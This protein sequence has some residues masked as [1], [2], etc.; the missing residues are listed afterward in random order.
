MNTTKPH[1]NLNIQFQPIILTLQRLTSGEAAYASSRN[2]FK[3]KENTL[4]CQLSFDEV[5]DYKCSSITKLSSNNQSYFINFQTI[6]HVKILLSSLVAF[7][8]QQK[9]QKEDFNKHFQQKESRDELEFF[10]FYS[11]CILA[12]HKKE[13]PIKFSIQKI[14]AYVGILYFNG[15]SIVGEIPAIGPMYGRYGIA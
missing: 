4:I 3:K 2:M 1:F 6:K 12:E 9:G 11:D 14:K 13:K 7:F 15:I 5:I 8:S 10:F